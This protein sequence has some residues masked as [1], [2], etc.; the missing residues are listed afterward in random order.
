MLNVLFYVILFATGIF[1]IVFAY[2]EPPKAI[3]HLF[4]IDA[5]FIFLPER[6]RVRIGRLTTGAL[7]LL[8]GVVGA[9]REVYQ[10][11]HWMLAR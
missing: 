3:D 9:V 4:R 8:A 7:I 6:N 11:I 2:R 5:I 10:E 1:Y